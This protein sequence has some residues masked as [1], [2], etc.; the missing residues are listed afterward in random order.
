MTAAVAAGESADVTAAMTSAADVTTAMMAAT[1]RAAPVM[2]AMMARI[3][4]V[5][6]LP[7]LRIDDPGAVIA[8]RRHLP[9]PHVDRHE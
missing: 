4:L 6:A 5:H 9:D 1:K 3:V 8:P 7:G 2:A